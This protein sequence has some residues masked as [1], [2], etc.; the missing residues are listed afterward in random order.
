MWRDIMTCIMHQFWFGFLLYVLMHLEPVMVS[1]DSEDENSGRRYL[2][3][4]DNTLR[5]LAAKLEKN[6]CHPLPS[7][8]RDCNTMDFNGSYIQEN[9]QLEERDCYSWNIAFIAGGKR[10]MVF[11]GTTEADSLDTNRNFKISCIET[12][13]LAYMRTNGTREKAKE[14]EPKTTESISEETNNL[15]TRRKKSQPTENP[16]LE[17][18]NG[19]ESATLSE[20]SSDGQEI[21]AN[22]DEMSEEG[23]VQCWKKLRRCRKRLSLN[24]NCAQNIYTSE[25]SPKFPGAGIL[26]ITHLLAAAIGSGILYLVLKKIGR[27]VSDK[28]K[29][30]R[31]K[32]FDNF[33]NSQQEK[34][35]RITI[36]HITHDND[37][38]PY[39]EVES[40]TP[41][42]QFDN[43]TKSN[44]FTG[45]TSSPG[46]KLSKLPD[47]PRAPE[48]VE[49]EYLIPHIRKDKDGLQT[50]K[51]V[52]Y[53]E[54]NLEDHEKVLLAGDNVDT[55]F[56]I[57]ANSPKALSATDDKTD[58]YFV[59]EK[60]V[61]DMDLK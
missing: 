13:T 35:T 39:H 50:D 49:Y 53:T 52:N 27:L 51:H 61:T 43:R 3:K 6:T 11:L 21:D 9:C 32:G 4:L 10:V 22:T 59:L 7:T 19:N 26:L 44:S 55:N 40:E 37:E 33:C 20:I 36:P 8:I 60:K 30:E 34:T 57:L 17:T 1:T 15:T 14:Q 5:T 31:N 23:F 58:D 24:N 56:E 2:K 54:L 18:D 16:I 28:N 38:N 41:T 42:I 29:S 12:D 45:S 48:K 47:I 46:R 25:D